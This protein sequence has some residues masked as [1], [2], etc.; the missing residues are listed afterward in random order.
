MPFIKTDA[1]T[2]EEKKKMRLDICKQCIFISCNGNNTN[3]CDIN[4]MICT[5][6]NEN[7]IIK[8]NDATSTCKMDYWSL[9]NKTLDGYVPSGKGCGCGR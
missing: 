8:T 3:K 9:S 1:Y 7:I 5:K 4:A 2:F 6:D